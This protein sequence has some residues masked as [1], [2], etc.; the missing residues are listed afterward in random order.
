MVSTGVLVERG[1]GDGVREGERELGERDYWL[2]ILGKGRSRVMRHC[3][4][5][6]VFKPRR[7]ILG[8]RV[9]AEYQGHG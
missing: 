3:V 8:Q 1:E 4:V 5:Y 2:T 9:F 7:R 6:G